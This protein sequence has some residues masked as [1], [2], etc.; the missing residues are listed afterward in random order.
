MKTPNPEIKDVRRVV[1]GRGP[2]GKSRVA[3]DST[4]APITVRALPGYAWHRLWSLDLPARVPND[5]APQVAARD[6]FP[7]PLGVR[8]CL[9]TVP[10]AGAAAV[11]DLDPA[12]AQAELDE[13]LPGRSRYMEEDQAGLHTTPTVDF[14]YVL[15]GEVW[16]ELNGKHQVHLRAGDTVIQNGTRHAWR[17]LSDEPC[18]MVVCLLGA[19]RG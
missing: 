19:E 14:V 7:P 1:T 9:F 17:N 3:S 15:S 5:G 11:A 2:G 16:L 6:H 4:V 8:F 10:P 13:K 12:A 18:Q